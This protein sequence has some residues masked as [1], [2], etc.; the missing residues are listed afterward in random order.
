M[1]VKPLKSVVLLNYEGL[2]LSSSLISLVT[3][4]GNMLGSRS[5]L[6]SFS[7]PILLRRFK[8]TLLKSK[9]EAM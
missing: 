5:S 1:L 8:N 7:L 2:V 6:R 3:S 9:T 4:Y